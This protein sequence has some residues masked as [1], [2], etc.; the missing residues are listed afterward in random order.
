MFV[1]LHSTE[2][3][4]GPLVKTL[5]IPQ[6]LRDHQAER[7]KYCAMS[8]YC[9]RHTSATQIKSHGEKKYYVIASDDLQL[10]CQS[11]LI[12]SVSRSNILGQP[13]FRVTVYRNFDGALIDDPAP[14]SPQRRLLEPLTALP[15]ASYLE[16]SGSVNMKYCAKIAARVSRTAPTIEECFVE[17]IQLMDKGLG[18]IARNDLKSAVEAYKMAY[19]HLSHFYIPRIAPFRARRRTDFDIRMTLRA[20]LAF[21]HYTLEEF[22]DAHFWALDAIRLGPRK[23]TLHWETLHAKTVYVQAIA[24]T[25]LGNYKQGVD[26][27]CNGLR[28]VRQEVYVDE[29]FVQW[30]MRAR[31]QIKGRDGG[32]KVRLL[33]A[34]GIEEYD[35]S[36]CAPDTPSLEQS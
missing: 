4:L 22:E 17:A 30:R 12:Q 14:S 15:S 23:A 29:G 26:E 28:L 20:N 18:N 32:D 9:G 33:R 3:D 16:F 34:M 13:K 36:D 1:R 27:L 2:Y 5:G 19:I 10:L 25:R 24:S 6:L 21:A 35:R 8:I 31:T 11:F 7:F